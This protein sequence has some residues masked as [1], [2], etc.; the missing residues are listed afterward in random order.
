LIACLL[1][2]CGLRLGEALNLRVKDLSFGESRLVLRDTKSRKDRAVMLPCS[3]IVPLQRQIA[4]ARLLWQEDRERGV[5]TSLPGLDGLRRKYPQIAHSW[6]WYYVF[7]QLGLCPDPQAEPERR[8][9]L[10]R[11]HQG[12]WGVQRAVKAA[13]RKCDLDGVLTPHAL[14]HAFASHL[15]RIEDPRTIQELLGHKSLETTMIYIHP[16]A[17][18]VE[19]PLDHAVKA[20]QALIEVPRPALTLPFTTA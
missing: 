14:R 3:L 1:Y 2:G 8:H 6:N 19:S 4:R 10:Y 20:A 5:P 18:R 7:P 11:H 12:E 17:A 15:S 9:V 13:A 16:R